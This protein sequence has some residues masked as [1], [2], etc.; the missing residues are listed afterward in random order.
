MKIIKYLFVFV[1]VVIVLVA[2]LITFALTSA[3]FQTRLAKRFAP[4]EVSFERVHLGLSGVQVDQL[5]VEQEDTLIELERL[6]G[7][8]SLFQTIFRRHLHIREAVITGLVIDLSQHVVPE[9]EVPLPPDYEIERPPPPTERPRPVPERVPPEDVVEPLFD[10]LFREVLD[11]PPLTIDLLQMDARILLPGGDQALALTLAGSDIHAAGTPTLLL[12]A[13]YEDHS[14]DTPLPEATLNKEIAILLSESAQVTGLTVKGDATSTVIV[15]EQRQR[16]AADLDIALRQLTDASGEVYTVQLSLT[17]DSGTTTEWLS[18]GA[19]Y[20]YGSHDL[21]GNWRISADTGAFESVLAAHLN[22][23]RMNLQSEAEFSFNTL[24][25]AANI[26]GTL[27]AAAAGLDQFR[28]ELATMPTA[29]VEATFALG[30]DLQSILINALQAHLSA[31]EEDRLIFVHAEQPFG[32]DLEN[33]APIFQDPDAPLARI[34]LAGFPTELVNSLVPDIDFSLTQLSGELLL[35]AAEDTMS[36]ETS[37]PLRVKDLSLAQEGQ[38]LIDQLS[39]SLAMRASYAGDEL[40]FTVTDLELYQ[41][42]H[43]LLALSA[44]GTIQDLEADAPMMD[45]KLQWTGD[46]AALLEQPAAEP[47]RNLSR[48]RFE[49]E[50]AL[51]GSP[52]DLVI[53]AGITLADLIRAADE[54][55][56]DHL[57]LQADVRLSEGNR[58]KANTPITV[59][60]LDQ[61]TSLTLDTDLELLADEAGIKVAMQG[62]GETVWLEHF[63]YL[64]EAFQNPAFVDP[65][66]PVV[67]QDEPAPTPTDE[68]D[69]PAPP[70]RDEERPPRDPVDPDD[71][72]VVVPTPLWAGVWLN[73]NLVIETLQIPD[74]PALHDVEAVVVIDEDEVTLERVHVRI[75]DSPVDLSGS[76]TFHADQPATLYQL[77]TDLSVQRFDVG[78]Y[79]LEVE[80]AQTPA[81][82]GVVSVS[83]H[84]E[85]GAPDLDTLA[86]R[87]VGNF[88][89][90]AESAIVRAFR[91]RGVSR[92]MDAATAASR[93]GDLVSGRQDID[94]VAEIVEY[95]REIKFDEIAIDARRNPDLSVDITQLLLRNRELL[96]EGSGHIG[97]EPDR[98]FHQQPMALNLDIGTREPLDRLFDSLRL[99]QAE[100]GEHGYRM[101]NRSVEVSGNIGEPDARPLW[102]IILDAGARRLVPDTRSRPADEE[103]PSDRRPSRLDRLQQFL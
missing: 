48:G 15:E 31:P 40:Q 54:A 49:G 11:W 6:S 58:I 82:E 19:K 61:T 14:E 95:F 36:I 5:R 43:A 3:G 80:P 50:L 55:P 30:G 89:I 81:F 69:D 9:T 39:L 8:F 52:D 85:G 35:T 60:H 12:T 17:D 24:T 45:L 28:E 102:V 65:D 23:A 71:A 77:W 38:A 33:Q 16:I 27:S 72:P 78:A 59:R 42:D 63:L 46:L 66:Q 13:V 88:S 4:E 34:T 76:L 100:P 70:P 79:L 98:S 86:E 18:L 83:G 91:Q 10:G 87:L 74:Q 90:K 96:M 47:F 7:Q 103:E 92:A 1:L 64:G 62:T 37:D 44:N 93:I 25:E 41:V 99:L 21:S 51:N 68:P 26:A 97:H 53:D 22:G 84:L 67:V 101:L 29:R 2:G 20:D 57:R 73:A 32:F 56:L 94:V 75:G